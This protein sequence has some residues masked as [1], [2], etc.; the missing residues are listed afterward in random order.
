MKKN[1]FTLLIT[2][3]IP[4][5]A[6]AQWS[7]TPNH[8]TMIADTIGSQVVPIVV[9]NSLGETYISWY[10]EFEDLNYD[11]YLQKMDKNGM[12]LWDEEGLLISDHETNT[13][14]TTYDMILDQ[15][16]NVIL[17]TQDMRTGNSDVFAYK[18]SPSGEFLWGDNG[19]Q[20]SNTTGFDPSPQ[21]TVTNNNDLIFLWGEEL[22][23]TTQNTI[24]F[25]T[26]Y[27]PDGN[28]LWE[29]NL[30]DTLDFM[31]PQMV[32]TNDNLIV[33]WITKIHQKDTIPGEE[34]WMHVFAQMLNSEGIPVWEH[35]VQIDSL[36]LMNYES[37]YTTP[38][39]TSDG[40]G[41]AYVMWESFFIVETGGMPTTYINRLYEDGTV[42]KPG[43]YS[44]SQFTGNY[45][46]EAQMVFLEDVEKLMVCW[47][48]YHY[49][50][51]NQIDCWGVYGQLFDADGGYLWDANGLEIIPLICSM[52]T[53]YS[54]ISLGQSMNN[55]VVLM[56]QKDYFS[57]DGSDTS[58]VTHIYATSL[59]TDG[60]M[61]WSPPLVPLSVT[62]SNKYQAALGNLVDN[63]WVLA[64]ND[65]ISNPNNYFD[66]GIY[67]QN[68]SVDGVLGPLSVPTLVKPDNITIVASPNPANN[69]VNIDYTLIS[70]G[71]VW[72]DLLDVNGRVLKQYND[73]KMTRGTYSQKID[74]SGL[75]PGMYII[76]L[77]VNSSH[78]Y[79]KII[80]N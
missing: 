62:S 64:W 33:S 75:N 9:T 49:D 60:D 63:Q 4:I 34:D 40:N 44:V 26:R 71:R 21:V 14:V 1:L 79:C 7:N 48:E 15:N 73:G 45:H 2:L 55:N 38:Y 27:S 37:L 78:V 25:V 8:N 74:I 68:I 67:A 16:E 72:I 57:I 41:G 23:D 42:W 31:L 53:S 29:T 22:I 50:H 39:L 13:W 32:Y 3:V 54:G 59:D 77:Q 76:K 11:V 56:Y 30:S 43:G 65:N 80:K 12:K 36:D 20:L 19:I 5:F 69:F 51:A 10:S 24:L 58:L 35:N 17:V 52:D 66:F 28:K 46:A 6:L 47:Q 61:I 70:N 18:I